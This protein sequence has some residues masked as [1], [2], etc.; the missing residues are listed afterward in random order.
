ME[1][2]KETR[3]LGIKGFLNIGFENEA[4]KEERRDSRFCRC[5]VNDNWKYNTKN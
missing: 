5:R 3:N 1:I 2:K 4:E